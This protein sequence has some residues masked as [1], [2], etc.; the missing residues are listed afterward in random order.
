[1]DKTKPSKNALNLKDLKPVCP[2]GYCAIACNPLLDYVF[3]YKINII[4]C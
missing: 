4:Y 1:M 2:V 3:N